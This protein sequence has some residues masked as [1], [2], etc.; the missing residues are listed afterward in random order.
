M[1][2]FKQDKNFLEYPLWLPIKTEQAFATTGYRYEFSSKF[3]HPEKF[4]ANILY[5]LM[6]DLEKNKWQNNFIEKTQ[7]QILVKAGVSPNSERYKR[8]EKCLLRWKTVTLI[9]EGSFFDG[10]GGYGSESF[11][12][13]NDWKINKKT[14][15]VSIFFNHVWLESIKNSKFFEMIDY[16][17]MQAL[18]NPT[19]SRLYELLIKNFYKRNVWKIDAHKLA[20]KIPLHEKYVAHIQ[21]KIETGVNNI[22]KKTELKVNLEVKKKERNKA[23][24]IFTKINKSE[25]KTNNEYTKDMEGLLR[26][27]PEKYNGLKTIHDA[28]QSNLKKFGAD[29]VKRNIS[30]ANKHAKKN[31][32]AYL[33]KA[34]KED[35]AIQEEEDVTSKQQ[36]QEAILEEFRK[37]NTKYLTQLAEGGNVFAKTILKERQQSF[38]FPG[39]KNE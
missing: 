29:Y 20:E 1:K 34:L 21:R 37:H 2:K 3:G 36:E 30:Y 17:V 11:G 39:Q 10:K 7:Y 14:G 26:L 9:Y 8:L 16:E 15:L 25:N 32:R 28:I 19:Y 35:W 6:R 33:V 27:V 18:K 31:Y 23:T 13:I 38:A 4:D 22:S 24:L 5:S 12:I